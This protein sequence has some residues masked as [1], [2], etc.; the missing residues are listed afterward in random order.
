MKA[1]LRY[2]IDRLRR[3]LPARAR[4]SIETDPDPAEPGPRH[5]ARSVTISW[6]AVG[7]DALEVRVGAPDGPLFCRSGPADRRTADAWIPDGTVF[8]LQNVSGN[9]PLTLRNTLA[10]AEV[11]VRLS[12]DRHGFGKNEIA[13]AVRRYLGVPAERVRVLPTNTGSLVCEVEHRGGSVVFKTS[14]GEDERMHAE[15]WTCDRLRAC[16]VPVPRVLAVDVSR[17]LLPCA[18]LI[19]EKVP[20]EPLDEVLRARSSQTPSLLREAGE[21]LRRIHAVTLEGAGRLDAALLGH[22]GT[23]R[24]RHDTWREAVLHDV[25]RALPFLERKLLPGNALVERIE[26]IVGSRDRILVES[27]QHHA[28]LHGDF[29]ARHIFVDS[30]RGRVTGV[31]DCEDARCGDPAFD[32]GCFRLGVG[33]HH[34]R[35]LLDGYGAGSD[36]GGDLAERMSFYG[37]VHALVGIR[38][39]YEGGAKDLAE[40]L[41]VLVTSLTDSIPLP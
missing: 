18:F 28:F 36:L 26:R 9:R 16:G 40:Q 15:A 37:L 31:I 5:H 6:T 7:T 3:S 39:C 1:P 33:E 34:L 38:D 10:T 41:L 11:S 12:E 24:G 32:F 19:M 14:R 30:E 2:L 35:L 17:R 8:Y 20:G 29:I 4:G 13:A 21:H 27:T 23:I 25:D 22:D